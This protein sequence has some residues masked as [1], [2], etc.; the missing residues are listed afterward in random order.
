MTQSLRRD[1]VL[2]GILYMLLGMGLLSIMDA[3]A[4]WMV[5]GGMNPIQI[6][7]LRSLVIVPAVWA[8][9]R[10]NGRARALKPTRHRWQAF[11][12][13]TGF[14][15]PFCFFLSLRTLPLSDAVVVFFSATFV[16]TGLSV[17]LLKEHV[18]VHRW[19]AVI[20]GYVGIVIAMVPHGGG[21][22]VGYMLVLV[23]SMAY[24]FLFVTGRMLSSTESIPSLVFSFNLGVG[25]IAFVLLPW[26]WV[27]MS[28][29]DAGLLMLLSVLAVLGHFSVTAAFSSAPVAAVAP[30]EYTALL[31][32]VGF[33]YFVW[34]QLPIATTWLG[35]A[36]I[37]GSGMYLIYRERRAATAAAQSI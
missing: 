23:S 5:E 3:V 22:L 12:G 6:L 9:F 36:V 19:T 20:V 33:D 16:S 31:W 34:Q 35:A 15:A 11:R 37:I 1:P 29:A 17:V 10:F 30:F 27:D 21:Q 8:V 32:A 25:L 26:F 24:A 7:A 13:V 2:Q 14:L 18:G 4:K 28:W